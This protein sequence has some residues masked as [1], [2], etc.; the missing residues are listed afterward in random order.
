MKTFKD[1]VEHLLKGGKLRR[2]NWPKNEYVHLVNG[3]LANEIDAHVGWNL[4]VLAWEPYEE[5]KT[6]EQLREE[7]AKKLCRHYG[8]TF[9]ADLSNLFFD[10]FE[11][12]KKS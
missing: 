6:E 12:R 8:A 9:S 1:K 3:E 5:P 7:F 2:P 10:Y 11:P 4:T